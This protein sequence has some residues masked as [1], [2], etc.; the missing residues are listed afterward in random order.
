MLCAGH[1]D[2]PCDMIIANSAVCPL[3]HYVTSCY[4][5]VKGGLSSL[6]PSSNIIVIIGGSFMRGIKSQTCLLP[7]HQPNYFKNLYFQTLIPKGRCHCW[8]QR[9]KVPPQSAA[10]SWKL[11]AMWGRGIRTEELLYYSQ[12]TLAM[13]GC[14][15]CCW[16]EAKPILRR[17]R[18]KETQH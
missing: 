17:Q 6:F 1:Q 4:K 12:L 3:I 18:Q 7:S 2:K 15:S 5:H 11:V 10:C 14:V 13:L 16:G 8:L 9:P